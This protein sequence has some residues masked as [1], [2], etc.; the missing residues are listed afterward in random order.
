MTAMSPS[1]AVR[2]RIAAFLVLAVA[3]L[4]NRDAQYMSAAE[5][6][7]G[8]YLPRPPRPW[9]GL[10]GRDL[11]VGLTTGLAIVDL[12]L[13]VPVWLASGHPTVS[14]GQR[15]SSTSKAI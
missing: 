7:A 11:A 6:I 9:F 15:V 14:L 5:D 12:V 2:F 13:I 3:A 10:R 4:M 8:H 1:D